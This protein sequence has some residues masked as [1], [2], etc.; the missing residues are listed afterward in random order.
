MLQER[1]EIGRSQLGRRVQARLMN[2]SAN[3]SETNPASL[4]PAMKTAGQAIAAT[5]IHLMRI[6][7]YSHNRHTWV[8]NH[9]GRRPF[10]SW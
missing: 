4:M 3:V 1:G 9:F 7:A 6:S 5:S 10:A 8:W 2:N